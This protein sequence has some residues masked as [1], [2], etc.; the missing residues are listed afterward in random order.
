MTGAL[1]VSCTGCTITNNR[2]RQCAVLYSDRSD[3]GFDDVNGLDTPGLALTVDW[4]TGAVMTGEGP[5]GVGDG[6]HATGWG[7]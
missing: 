3:N 7:A 4:G 5:A 1:T 6:A 2:A